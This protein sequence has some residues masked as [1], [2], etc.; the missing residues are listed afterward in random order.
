MGTEIF[1]QVIIN[2]L[3]IGGIYAL[4]SI[5]LTLLFGVTDIVNF[6]HGEYL[7]LGMYIT[8]FTWVAAGLDPFVT[9]VISAAGMFIVGA[10]IQRF[11]FKHIM[12]A[13]PLAQI[14][15]TVGLQMILQN[16]SLMVF[17]S[18]LRRVQPSYAEH[19][20]KLGGLSISTPKLVAFGFA[21]I[22]SLALFMFLSKTDLGKAMKAAQQD[23][24]VAMLMGIN[25]DRIFMIAAGIAGALTGAAGAAI[26]TYYPI[27]PTAGA[28]F[29]LMA[30]IT[31]ILGSLGN[32]KGAFVGG[33]V[34]GLAESVGIQ[35]ISADAG[36]LLSFIIFI[37]VLVFRPE[38]LFVGKEIRR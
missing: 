9:M 35:F 38:G 1:L 28:M 2:G 26:S 32:L 31:V 34:L 27:Q 4:V 6:A 12:N 15:L 16:T 33:L 10:V 13:P 17:G 22:L 21:M 37:G 19:V 29:G 23:R 20:V 25:T 8:Y 7:M 11:L 18:N 14:F 36:R 3:V 24:Q 30:Y 5:G